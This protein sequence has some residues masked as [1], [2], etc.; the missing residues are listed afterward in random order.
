MDRLAVDIG[1]TFVDA[2]KYE[3]R[4]NELT[5]R[6]SD[7][8][9]DDPTNGVLAAIQKSD[10]Q[11]GQT[12]TFVHGTTLGL[13]ALL[14][15]EGATT[16]ILTNEGF[17]DVFE[18]GRYDRPYEEMFNLTYEKPDP[19][20]PR[21]RRKGIPGRLNN[22]GEV[23]EPIDEDAVVRATVELVEDHGVDSIAVCLLHSYQNPDHEREVAQIIESE[24]PNLSLSLS[25]DITREY[26]EYER[27][28]TTVLDAYIK[29][30]YESYVDRLNTDLKDAGFDGSF[31]ITR[32]GGGALAAENAKETPVHSILSGPAGG[33]IGATNVAE[34]TENGHLIAADMGGTSVDACVIQNGSPIIEHEAE[35]E[36]QSLQI[37]VYDIRTIGAG[38]GSIAWLDG[39]LL[40]VGPKSAGAEPGPICYDRGGSQPTVTDAAVM[41][42]YIDPGSFLGGEMSLNESKA[43]T[44]IRKRLAHPLDSTVS[45][46]SR[47]VFDVLAGN[48]VNAIGEIT[49][50][51][52]LDPRE[53]SL[54]AYGGA[55][56]MIMPLVAREM[57]VDT[58]LVPQ[59]PSVFSAWGMLLSDVVYDYSQTNIV[60]LDETN[61]VEIDAGFEPLER[62]SAEKLS[63]EGFDEAHQR[64]ERAIE[65]R[66]RGQEHTVEVA[67]NDISSMT[68]LEARFHERY[69]DRFGHRMENPVEIAHLRV[70]AIGETDKPSI[71]HVADSGET[72]GAIGSKQTR[73]AYCFAERDFVEF[74]V[75]Q[76]TA[77][78]TDESVSGPA[79]IQEPTT[80]IIVYS[81]QTA[82]LDE[83]GHIEIDVNQ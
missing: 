9:Q 24:F 72:R 39:E 20:V 28:N 33:I 6:K 19:L 38:G 50:E 40:K 73:E 21:F 3:D 46:V 81:D 48:I 26:R 65:M 70:R 47:G 4:T 44:E 16:G 83:H 12:D 43:R 78:S 27:T 76:R 14:E 29:P 79:I 77:L 35:I 31:F 53:F 18:L 32:S 64:I 10:P 60:G 80:T 41:L 71:A 51:R 11:L 56:P 30:I 2:V 42:G 23:I 8:T 34:E 1:G 69:A 57:D 54:L 58:V 75:R 62:R 82:Q 13:N 61:T 45:E 68:E 52:G 74:D 7:T 55:G 25:S 17:I 15:R 67:A 37:P 59:A 66:Y 22:E 5:I 63:E 49:V 36:S